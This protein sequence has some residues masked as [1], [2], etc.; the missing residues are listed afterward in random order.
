[1]LLDCIIRS[2]FV[3]LAVGLGWGIRGDFGHNLGAMYPGAALG[4]AFAYVSGS[5]HAWQWAPVLG[6]LGGLGIGT[7]GTM[8]YGMLHG[9]AKAD[10]F[11]NYAY[12][13][14]TLFLQG[15]AWGCF[16]CCAIALALDKNQIKA[17]Q[18][19]SLVFTIL[20]FGYMLYLLVYKV[21][22]FDVNPYRD[23]SMI[24]Y[25][26]GVIALFVWLIWHKNGSGLRG[27]ILGYIGFGFGMAFGRYLG[28]ASYMLPFAINHWNIME[29]MC[30]FIGGFI[31]T[32]GMLGVKLEE[33]VEENDFPVLGTYGIFYVMFGIPFLHYLWRVNPGEKM[34][35]WTTRL[36]TLGY[37]NP[38]SIIHITMIFVYIV[39][40]LAFVGAA[41]WCYLY[42]KNIQRWKWFPILF[43]SFIML[44]IQCLNA[45]YFLDPSDIMHNVN[46]CLLI[47]MTLFALFY[48]ITEFES[49]EPFNWIFW[50]VF[51]IAGY[52]FIIATAGNINGEETMKS[53]NT[54]FPLWSWTEG[55]PPTSPE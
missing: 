7:G 38:E 48:P 30:G 45:S 55:P 29:V 27:A 4:L 41:V 16:G 12:G 22:G 6:L 10:T 54:R 52:I 39:C 8:S 31:F 23:N 34:E 14:F 15:G 37:T 9:Y 13:F 33:Y 26:G 18:L 42:H 17:S 3:A 28:N 32:F 49:E 47:L 36:T 2:L 25:T 40:G 20:F 35:G 21:I 50:M 44:M 24:G 46:I 19:F 51:G 1:M 43:F 5:R 53:A 11:I